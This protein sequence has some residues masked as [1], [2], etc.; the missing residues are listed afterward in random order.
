VTAAT[1]FTKGTG[2]KYQYYYAT[3]LINLKNKIT[4][5]HHLAYTPSPHLLT[6]EGV[7]IFYRG[8]I[9]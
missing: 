4:P 6:E 5:F 3:N 8:Y 1:V 9:I 2:K 7:Y